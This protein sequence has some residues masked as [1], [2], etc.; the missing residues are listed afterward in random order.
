MVRHEINDF[1]PTILSHLDERVLHDCLRFIENHLEKPTA[2]LAFE[3]FFTEEAG[4]SMFLL[5]KVILLK[6][7]IEKVLKLN[8][9]SIAFSLFLGIFIFPLVR[10]PSLTQL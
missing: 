3:K 4:R 2:K 10:V 7:V 5:K 9:D 8:S 1:F 6:E